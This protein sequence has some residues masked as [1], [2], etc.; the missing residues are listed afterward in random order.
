MSLIITSSNQSGYDQTSVGTGLSDPANYQ[1]FFKSP[2]TIAPHSEIAVQSVKIQRGGIGISEDRVYAMYWG[3]LPGTNRGD[4]DEYLEEPF[5]SDQDSDVDGTL[6]SMGISPTRPVFI[7]IPK[8]EYTR[9]QFAKELQRLTEKTLKESFEHIKGVSINVEYDSAQ[10]DETFRGWVWRLEQSGNNASDTGSNLAQMDWT[11]YIDKQT[12]LTNT[13]TGTTDNPDKYNPPALGQYGDG[14]EASGGNCFY[15]DKFT[16]SVP[17]PNVSRIKKEEDVGVSNPLST[18]CEAIGVGTPLGLSDGACIFDLSGITMDGSYDG[19]TGF[20]CGLT[21]NLVTNY[22][23]SATR[24]QPENQF[25]KLDKPFGFDDMDGNLDRTILHRTIPMFYDYAVIWDGHRSL[26][27]M[28]SDAQDWGNGSDW[29]KMNMV[30]FH[31]S[32]HESFQNASLSAGYWDQ[33]KFYAKGERMCLQMRVA[34]TQAWVDLIA[35]DK[36]TNGERFKPISLSNNLLYPKIWI[37]KDGDHVDLVAWEGGTNGYSTP[38]DPTST[39][40]VEGQPQN[41][42]TVRKYGLDLWDPTKYTIGWEDLPSDWELPVNS[43]G[44]KDELKARKYD[45]S[46]DTSR[47]FQIKYTTSATNSYYEPV[48]LQ[49]KNGVDYEWCILTGGSDRYA[50][51]YEDDMSSR[52]GGADKILGLSNA[53]EYEEDNTGKAE[54]P[55]PDPPRIQN[56]NHGPDPADQTNLNYV[57]MFSQEPPKALAFG[58]LF[59]RVSSLAHNSYNGTKSSISKILYAMP[60]WD[61]RG[62]IDGALYYEPHERV[63]L[64]LNYNENNQILNDLSVQIVNNNEEVARDLEGNTVVIFHIRQ[65]SAKHCGNAD[66]TITMRV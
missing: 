55:Q 43:T 7:T 27:V 8:G 61:A 50:I 49:A 22:K 13:Q 39:A 47:I 58:S 52:M 66:E 48:G 42:Y 63:Y 45:H 46:I 34:A 20:I 38:G 5:I 33:I 60:R 54:S 56:F 14:S 40:P 18:M 3:Q 26:R 64:D 35:E 30:E 21:R 16:N 11:P 28:Q 31:N 44:F 17:S 23:S 9:T 1:N 37:T 62:E 32:A 10:A 2:I 57:V 24:T 51:S 19:T 15:T 4:I 36:N 6:I 12:Q 25:R 29:T 59:I 53:L 65:K 41:Y